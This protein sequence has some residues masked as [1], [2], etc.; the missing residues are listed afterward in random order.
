MSLVDTSE[1][2]V[3]LPKDESLADSASED[4]IVVDRPRRVVAGRSRSQPV[5]SGRKCLL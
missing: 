4:V 5:R 2:L 1:R 3:A